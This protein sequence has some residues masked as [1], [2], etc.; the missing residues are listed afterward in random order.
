MAD[1]SVKV[2][3]INNTQDAFSAMS[4]RLATIADEAKYV[5]SQVGRT[6]VGD[7]FDTIQSFKTHN[8][9]NNCS[10]DM[11]NLANALEK[12]AQLYNTTEKCIINKDFSENRTVLFNGTLLKVGDTILGFVVTEITADG[13]LVLE[14][15]THILIDVYKALDKYPAL[16]TAMTVL[17]ASHILFTE[18]P[19]QDVKQKI[20]VDFGNWEDDGEA[21]NIGN[22]SGN[23]DGSVYKFTY[24]TEGEYYKSELEYS[25]L[26]VNGEG[27]ISTWDPEK[28]LTPTNFF[29]GEAGAGVGN[30]KGNIR[31]GME[32]DNFN[33]GIEVDALSAQANA[34]NGMGE[35]SYTDA[36]GEKHEGTGLA[37]GVGASASVVEGAITLQT[38]KDGKASTVS[39]SADYLGAGGS[40]GLAVTDEG[41]S[42]N[43]DVEAII[44]VGL[45]ISQEW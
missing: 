35:V 13:R 42:A 39:V 7:L 24:I 10:V 3:V 38:V 40:A 41:M 31:I 32:D 23:F 26:N 25:V 2:Q 44:G 22:A 45:A 20:I 16:K 18:G 33:I 14:R 15:D 11:K 17:N 43:I 27:E 6:A 37:K 36:A 12:I 34:N 1:F 29:N 5:I 30:I 8:D 4:G 19:F 28:F 9:I 21:A